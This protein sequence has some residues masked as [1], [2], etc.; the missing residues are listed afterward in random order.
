MKK[1]R[2]NVIIPYKTAYILFNTR[3]QSL[4]LLTKEFLDFLIL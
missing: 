2:Y 4:I 3:T 1:S